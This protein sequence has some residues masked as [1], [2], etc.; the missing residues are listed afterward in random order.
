MELTKS[1]EK[2][3]SALW[4]LSDNGVYEGPDTEAGL[5]L[6]WNEDNPGLG[7]S[8]GEVTSYCFLLSP[9]LEV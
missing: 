8:D 2:G 9:K 7:T 5:V 4:E 3:L 6:E 1:V